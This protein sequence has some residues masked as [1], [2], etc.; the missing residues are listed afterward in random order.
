MASTRA[1]SSGSLL[2][3]GS[4]SSSVR[5]NALSTTAA[6]RRSPRR[7]ATSSKPRAAAKAVMPGSL[8][9]L[10]LKGCEDTRVN[11]T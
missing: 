10:P 9:P 6:A 11:N 4:E 1:A 8:L 7:T 5:S 3:R 2:P